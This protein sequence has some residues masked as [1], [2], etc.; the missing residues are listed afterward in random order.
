MGIRERRNLVDSLLKFDRNLDGSLTNDEI[1]ATIR[2]CFGLGP[3]VHRELVALRQVNPKSDSPV[4]T[5]P[6]WFVRMD[7]NKDNDIS[8]KEF[9]GTKE[10]FADLDTDRDA[11]VSAQ[12]ALDYDRRNSEPSDTPEPS[13]KETTETPTNDTATE[14]E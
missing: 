9:P 6:D 1:Q 7:R 11:L 5:G 13:E 10:Q 14:T 3:Q 4:V 2:V 12:E 8:S